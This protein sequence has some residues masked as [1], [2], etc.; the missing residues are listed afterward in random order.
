MP[1]PAALRAFEPGQIRKEAALRI[2]L[3]CRGS[4]I[5]G[6][7]SFIFVADA[8]LAGVGSSRTGQMF[9]P[10]EV[11]M[12]GEAGRTSNGENRVRSGRKQP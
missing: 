5:F 9:N 11:V 10:F 7:G 4:F 8:G 1:L 3:R 12:A 2:A 6:R